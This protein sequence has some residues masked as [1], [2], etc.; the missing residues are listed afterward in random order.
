MVGVGGVVGGWL[1]LAIFAL[2]QLRRE[3]L[4]ETDLAIWAALILLIPIGGAIAFW[5]VQPSNGFPGAGE[6][7]REGTSEFE[8]KGDR[9]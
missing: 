6:E 9:Q 3:D 4:P 2:F 8:T 5:I 1:I 7:G